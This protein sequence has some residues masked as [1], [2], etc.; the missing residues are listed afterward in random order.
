[1]LSMH[2]LF[3]EKLKEIRE[4]LDQFES[5]SKS[6]MKSDKLK[7]VLEI[8]FAVGSIFECSTK[9]VNTAHGFKLST[10]LRCFSE[11]RA[12]R[13]ISVTLLHFVESFIKSKI[14]K[15]LNFPND[16]ECLEEASKKSL[17]DI[18]TEIRGFIASVEIVQKESDAACSTTDLT[19]TPTPS[20]ERSV[21]HLF[22]I[23]TSSNKL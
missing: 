6:I 20:V 18:I 10:S 9:H 16:I 1:M 8:L 5:A 14:P 22:P 21:F 7:G 17:P 15:Y 4:Q 11:T 23:S 2:L 13:C 12:P 3:Q 19:K